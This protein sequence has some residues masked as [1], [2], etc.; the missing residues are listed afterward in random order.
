MKEE[1]PAM[2][3]FRIDGP[4]IA[5]TIPLKNGPAKLFEKKHQSVCVRVAA[6]LT[7]V[8]SA[9]DTRKMENEKSKSC[10]LLAVAL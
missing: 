10:V 6:R 3:V 5:T 7:G 1:T 9:T 4:V 8:Q 2:I